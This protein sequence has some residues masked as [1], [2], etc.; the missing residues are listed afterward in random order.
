[1]KARHIVE[2]ES[3]RRS[4]KTLERERSAGR[5]PAGLAVHTDGTARLSLDDARDYKVQGNIHRMTGGVQL[6]L[7]NVTSLTTTIL[8]YAFQDANHSLHQPQA[9]YIMSVLVILFRN[10]FFVFLKCWCDWHNFLYYSV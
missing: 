6:R 10:S 5:V 1:M 4:G 2:K 7:S 9:N 3:R 8:G